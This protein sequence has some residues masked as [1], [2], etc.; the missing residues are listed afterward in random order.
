MTF[1]PDSL[2]DLTGRVFIVTGATSGIG[3]H[4]AARLAEHGAHVY[5]CA[6]SSAKASAASDRIKLTYPHARLSLLEM[7]HTS[8]STVVAA[9]K[10]FL[11]QET[12]LH[13]LINNAGI[14]ATPFETTQD[15]YEIQWQTNYLAH[16]VF[17]R[18][19]IPLLLQTAQTLPPGNV[20][21]VDLSSSGHHSAPKGGINFADTSL[22]DASPIARYG[23]SKLANILHVKTLNTLYGPDADGSGARGRDAQ[24]WTAAVHPGLVDTNIA[25]HASLPILLKLVI[26]PYKAIGGML[27][28]DK[29]SWT[30]VFCAASPLLKQEHSGAYFQRV[31]D[32]KGWQSAM[33]KNAELAARLED[34]TAREMKK[35]GWID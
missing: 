4:T 21:V 2:P 19:L 7:D 11:S 10:H 24:I 15:G 13:G 27:D 14:M 16:W 30:S 6:R 26:A 33:A 8:L 3:Y 31:A 23:Q 12:T 22:K 9:A 17:T 34:W 28:G 25:E 35:G 32:P 1:H 18:H 29:G 20:R 5:M